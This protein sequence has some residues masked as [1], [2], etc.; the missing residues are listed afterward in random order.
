MAYRG[1]WAP[2]YSSAATTT[3][4]AIVTEPHSISV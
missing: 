4:V 2:R 1:A 3:T